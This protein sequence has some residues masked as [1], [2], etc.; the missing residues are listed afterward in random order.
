MGAVGQNVQILLCVYVLQTLKKHRPN[1]SRKQVPI[2]YMP[3]VSFLLFSLLTDSLNRYC[4]AITLRLFYYVVFCM[5]FLLSQNCTTA[6][7]KY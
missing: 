7:I 5:A 3:N 4:K 1:P 6:V 2:Q